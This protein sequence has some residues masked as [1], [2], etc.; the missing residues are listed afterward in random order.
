MKVSK[1]INTLVKIFKTSD[2][3]VLL[4]SFL[5]FFLNLIKLFLLP[6]ITIYVMKRDYLVSST[7]IVIYFVVN[8]SLIL[9]KEILIN[10]SN[11]SRMKRIEKSYD[12]CIN[13]NYEFFESYEGRNLFTKAVSTTNSTTSPFSKIYLSIFD[14]LYTVL[15]MGFV[16]IYSLKFDKVLFFKNIIFSILICLVIFFDNLNINQAY[17]KMIELFISKEKNLNYLRKIAKQFEKSIILNDFRAKDLYQDKYNINEK[18]IING[19]TDIKKN[20]IL[21]LGLSDF[22]KILVLFIYIFSLKTT[23]FTLTMLVFMIQFLIVS[24]KFFDSFFELNNIT[25]KIYYY[26]KFIEKSE[27]KDKKIYIDEL[28]CI[29]F[30]NVYFSYNNSDFSLKNIN[31]KLENNKKIGIFGSNGCGKTTIV[32][33]LLGLY[34]V[35][36]GEILI[37]GINIDKISNL[38]ELIS[39]VFQDD[40]VIPASL[41]ENILFG[42]KMNKR[43]FSKAMEESSFNEVMKK[44]HLNN[45]TYLNS[46]YVDDAKDLSMGES[47]LLYLA[48]SI[49]KNTNMI[50]WDE[51]SSNLD[52]FRELRL[53]TKYK[54]IGKDSMGIFISHKA[55]NIKMFDEI[56]FM[57]NGQIIERGNF[58]DLMDKKGKYY[59]LYKKQEENFTN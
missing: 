3:E 37:N 42:K 44:N 5:Y 50:I 30:K 51:P 21:K 52:P 59:E 27:S 24:N 40:I 22:C 47:Q 16:I 34:K 23:A 7:M 53:F 39:C 38:N 6:I 20:M 55:S 35:K 2:K 4:Y 48:R 25:N 31:I 18:N 14:T 17:N 32:K 56:I 9:I 8:Y 33:L 11:F 45:K 43:N 13:I 15:Y 26:Y 12:A 57:E 19:C 1:K 46:L 28:N 29:E 36:R 54:K 41:E 10:V 49:Y 58:K